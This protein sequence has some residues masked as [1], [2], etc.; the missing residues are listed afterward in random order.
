MVVGDRR[1]GDEAVDLVLRFQR[2]GKQF[3]FAPVGKLRPVA[4]LAGGGKRCA[5]EG[6]VALRLQVAGIDAD[7]IA[8][9]RP[10]DAAGCP[11]STDW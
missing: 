2:A 6:P 9:L 1:L 3:A 5:K 11:G 7:P 8:R 10:G 4:D